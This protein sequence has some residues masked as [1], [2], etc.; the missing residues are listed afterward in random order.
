MFGLGQLSLVGLVHWKFDNVPQKFTNVI[1]ESIVFFYITCRSQE[2]H[3]QETFNLV[4]QV[5]SL[6]S[7]LKSV[8]N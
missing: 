3:S 6:I 5:K 2:T 7:T 4:E 8:L 1:L